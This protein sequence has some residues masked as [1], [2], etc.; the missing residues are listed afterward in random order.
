MAVSKQ[1]KQKHSDTLD[2]DKEGSVWGSIGQKLFPSVGLHVQ[3]L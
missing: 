3:R 1:K 2:Y